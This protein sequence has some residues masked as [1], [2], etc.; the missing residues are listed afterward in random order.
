MSEDPREYAHELVEN[1][2]VSY[3][4]LATILLKHMSKEEVWQALDNNEL[5][6]RFFDDN[7]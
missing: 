6:P 3:E 1:E 7:E 4:G 2:R 5:T